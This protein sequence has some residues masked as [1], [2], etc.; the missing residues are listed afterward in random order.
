MYENMYYGPLLQNSPD[1]DFVSLVSNG[2]DFVNNRD[3]YYRWVKSQR[4]YR[5]LTARN[6]ITIE[7]YAQN[8][9]NIVQASA[10][11]FGDMIGRIM[12]QAL[13]V[14]IENNEYEDRTFNVAETS[15]LTDGTTVDAFEF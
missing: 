14:L 11:G 1:I 12:R 6:T 4:T 5:E 2:V 7:Q 13:D 3:E 8:L 9:A 10:S 15:L